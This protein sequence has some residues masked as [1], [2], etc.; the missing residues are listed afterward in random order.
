MEITTTI[1]IDNLTTESVS[2]KTQK[3]LVNGGES[4]LLGEPSRTA[5]TKDQADDVKESVPEPFLSAIL[6]V[7]GISKAD[8]SEEEENEQ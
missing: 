6:D 3:M 2:V 5:Y 1:T 8:E 7:W 4:F